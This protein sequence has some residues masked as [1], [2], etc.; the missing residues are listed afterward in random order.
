MMRLR[1][2]APGGCAPLHALRGR[3]PPPPPLSVLHTHRMTL[4]PGV[5]PPGPTATAAAAAAASRPDTAA[6]TRA[7]SRRRTARDSARPAM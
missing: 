6:S 4:N 3:L 7:S 5:T 2:G 1:G